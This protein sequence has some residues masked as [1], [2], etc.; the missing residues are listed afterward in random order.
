M[1]NK[2]NQIQMKLGIYISIFFL[3]IA[4]VASAQEVPADNNKEVEIILLTGGGEVSIEKGKKISEQPV[5]VDTVNV[6]VDVSYNTIDK[7]VENNFKVETIK[8]PKLLIMEPLDKLSHGQLDL[9]LN[10]FKSPPFLNFTYSTLRNKDY[11][12]GIKIRHF[13][14]DLSV[15]NL[16]STRFTETGA[17]VYGKKFYKNMVVSGSADYNYNTFR[18]FGYDPSLF[19]ISENS[20]KRFYSIFDLNGGV[21]SRNK[22]RSAWHQKAQA[23]YQQ[24]FGKVNIEEHLIS[25]SYS[26]HTYN[27]FKGKVDS[28][29]PEKDFVR[30][31]SVEL[32]VQHLLSK[33]T[34][35]LVESTLFDVSLFGYKLKGKGFNVK[36]NPI[37]STFLS[38]K[39]RALLWTPTVEI[40]YAI[41]KDIF[42]LYGGFERKL[43]RNHYLTYMQQ[44]PFIGANLPHTNTLTNYH[45]SAGLKGALTSKTTFNLGAHYR[46][47]KDFVLFVNDVN[48]KAT[49]V[50]NVITDDVI[51]KQV[52]GELMY[53][54]KKV[55]TGI[56]VE[57]NVYEVFNNEAY[58]LPAIKAQAFASYNVQDKFSIGTDIFYYGKQLALDVVAATIPVTT[59]ELKP[60]LDFNI[61]IDYHYSDK[62]GAFL[63][64]NNILSTKHQRWNQYPNYGINVLGGVS[65]T[66]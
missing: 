56:L 57:Y 42:I 19:N 65:Y 5:F 51:H 3:L 53:E 41:A 43:E 45:I 28:L 39:N 50:Y 37:R 33:D 31:S 26:G 36:L 20:D 9:G 38:N 17:G 32:S 61:S 1:N 58:H 6:K 8:P 59:I 62:L 35:F 40:D 30:M 47:V 11:N 63:K 15:K 44:N 48:S 22:E 52:F 25:A 14:S 66:F 34:T 55:K 60:I 49:R 2:E 18:N 29:L 10:D 4:L 24:L 21:E 23:R 13:S 7:K 54:N 46:D 64:V 27:L 16:S 12:A